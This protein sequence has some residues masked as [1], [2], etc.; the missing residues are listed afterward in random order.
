M[1]IHGYKPNFLEKNGF[2]RRHHEF[3]KLFLEAFEL[4]SDFGKQL[5][6]ESVFA[7]YS[8]PMVMCDNHRISRCH[9]RQS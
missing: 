3:G 4:P 2:N 6:E 8:F 5:S 9:L 7:I 1:N